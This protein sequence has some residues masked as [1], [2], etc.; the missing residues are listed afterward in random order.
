MHRPVV[1]ERGIAAPL[2]IERGGEM[3]LH[4]GPHRGDLEENA[5]AAVEMVNLLREM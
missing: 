3:E 1:V 2:R 5:A 4:D